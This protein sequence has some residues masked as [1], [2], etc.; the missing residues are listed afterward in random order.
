M[1]IK[2]RDIPKK[3]ELILD[4]MVNA[5]EIGLLEKDIKVL[6]PLTIHAQL[7]RSENSVTGTTLVKG[8][9]EY[10]CARC[11]EPVLKEQSDEIDVYFEVDPTTEFVDLGDEIRQEIIIAFSTV[12]LCKQDCKGICPRCGANLNLEEC[13]C[14]K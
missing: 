3:D 6:S 12:I 13:R 2:V 5:T 14:R 10:E 4:K 1:K 8:K 7:Q 9:Y 11:L